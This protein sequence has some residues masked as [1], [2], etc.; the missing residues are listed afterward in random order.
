MLSLI[1]ENN[2]IKEYIE[3]NL[4]MVIKKSDL[5][6][7]RTLKEIKNNKINTNANRTSSSKSSNGNIM[8][9]STNYSNEKIE[10]I[11]PVS[12]P[13]SDNK[14]QNK[15]NSNAENISI[16]PGGKINKKQ[17]EKKTGYPKNIPKNKKNDVFPFL[18][19]DSLLNVNNNCINL[20]EDEFLTNYIKN[21][22]SNLRVRIRLN[23]NNKVTVDRYIQ[24]KNDTN[25][26][27]DSYND[28]IKKY[29]K[30]NND[31]IYDY[32]QNNKFE[33]L[34]NSFNKQKV[35]YSNLLSDDE[36][37]P[38]TFSNEL[39]N[40]SNSHKQFMKQKRMQSNN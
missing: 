1:K 31:N 28:E 29:K 17:I 25:P 39:K 11:I 19:L 6:E 22:N 24:E 33:K 30:Y 10:E 35:N 13:S 21:Q 16:V 18:S 20:D 2:I 3:K 4:K 8:T 37:D 26:F 38:T 5:N 15:N 40:F 36:E 9:T 23:R 7:I 32:E 34:L 14:S 27:H 12:K